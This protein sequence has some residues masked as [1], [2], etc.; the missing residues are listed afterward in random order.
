MGGWSSPAPEG[1]SMA[2]TQRRCRPPRQLAAAGRYAPSDFRGPH[3]GLAQKHQGI[4]RG[5]GRGSPD[6][7]DL[8]ALRAFPIEV[9]GCFPLSPRWQADRLCQ[10]QLRRRRGVVDDFQGGE[11]A[12]WPSFECA[13]KTRRHQRDRLPEPR[14]VSMTRPQGGGTR[15]GVEEAYHSAVEKLIARA[16][17]CARARYIREQMDK[18]GKGPRRKMPP[19]PG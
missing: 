6:G 8:A 18:A 2:N 15:R 16:G 10:R 7:Q 11:R 14:C 4:Q 17:R 3:R 9:T 12:N 19:A 5:R 13:L 1:L